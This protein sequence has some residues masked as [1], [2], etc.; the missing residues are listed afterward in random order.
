MKLRA[1]ALQWK[2][3]K[4]GSP[5]IS[6]YGV[7]ASGV[8]YDKMPEAQGIAIFMPGII[9]AENGFCVMGGALWYNDNFYLRLA[10]K[11]SLGCKIFPEIFLPFLVNL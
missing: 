1:A 8:L 6:P 11:N 7:E 3:C 2:F 9:D 5:F 4:C 10:I